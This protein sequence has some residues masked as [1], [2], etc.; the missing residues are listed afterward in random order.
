VNTSMY[1]KMLYIY[2][3]KYLQSLNG[4]ERYENRL[5]ILQSYI[6]QIEKKVIQ[7]AINGD[8]SYTHIIHIT[9]VDYELF[10]HQLFDELEYIYSDC[11]VTLERLPGLKFSVIEL[12]A[13]IEW[14]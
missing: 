2:T 6:S 7:H 10:Y 4:D 5:N 11:K 9:P 14:I 3:K 13:T 8:K 12:S 1:S